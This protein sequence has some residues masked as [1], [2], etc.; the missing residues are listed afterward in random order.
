MLTDPRLKALHYRSHHRGTRE[1]DMMIGGFFDRY[2]RGWNAA[3]IAWFEAL[4]DEE[5][6][7][8]MAWAIG[9]SPP[10]PRVAGPMM[11][12]MQRLDYIEIAQ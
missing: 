6:V 3:E 2:H 4:M 12:A 11:N 5:D 1:A 8:I 9:A 7:D 10:P